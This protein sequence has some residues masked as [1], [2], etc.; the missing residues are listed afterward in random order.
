L[1]DDA[2]SLIDEVFL[3]ELEKRLKLESPHDWFRQNVL[4]TVIHHMCVPPG[5][6]ASVSRDDLT[7]AKEYWDTMQMHL[8]GLLRLL[9]HE[10]FKCK[11]HWQA[12]LVRIEVI[13]K[14]P[15][16]EKPLRARQLFDGRVWLEDLLAKAAAQVIE[17]SNVCIPPNS[18]LGA[19]RI[20]VSQLA[21]IF[22]ESTG[23]DPH[24]HIK[25]NYAKD[26]YSGRFFDFADAILERLGNRQ[27]ASARGKMIKK[28]L[29]TFSTPEK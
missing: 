7:K 11:E 23:E 27:S 16:A 10:N 3:E 18:K 24:K 22:W 25:G 12:R 6:L 17:L 26:K 28:Q 29:R 15:Q 14:A 13:G 1:I 20:L 8:S 21:G 9:P 4:T 2:R 5:G 19:E